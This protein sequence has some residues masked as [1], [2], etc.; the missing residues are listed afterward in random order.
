MCS[1]PWSKRALKWALIILAAGLSLPAGR[2]QEAPAPAAKP[3]EAPVSPTVANYVLSPNDLIQIRVFQEDDLN[4]DLRI[5]KDGTI[6]FPLLGAVKVGGKTI[7]QATTHIR[8]LL[9]KDYLVNPQVT[10][11]ISQYSKRRFAVLGQ[12]SRSGYYE[13]PNE[14]TVTLLQAIAMAGGYTRIAD[15]SRITLKR[16]G[17]NGEQVIKLNGKAMARDGSANQFE[18]LPEDTITVGE[19][20]F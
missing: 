4:S 8:D 1:R 17:P 2:A 10:I 18:V 13:M 12:V 20:L 7:T 11:N 16:K 14:E 3:A 5:A 6:V 19:S 9:L 15:P